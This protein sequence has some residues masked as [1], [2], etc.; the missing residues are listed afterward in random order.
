MTIRFFE[1]RP[2]WWPTR[3]GWILIFTVAV[4]PPSFWTI[5]G[6]TFL[7]AT[8][9]VPAD[10]LVVEGWIGHEGLVAAKTEFDQG[11]YRY[12][13]TSGSDSASDWDG[14][15]WNYAIGAGELLK[16]LGVPAERIIKAPAAEN[17]RQRTFAMALAVREALA[18]HAIH[19]SGINI[20]TK[21]AHARRSRLVYAKVESS[22]TPVG[23]IAWLPWEES[24]G[25]WWGS[26]NRA[27][28]LLKESVGYLFEAVLNSGR[29][30]NSSPPSAPGS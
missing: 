17:K 2:M 14:R 30:S 29:T 23:V 7:A 18:T 1:R 21:G 11:G 24:E 13:V 15:K 16:Q 12:V 22:E 6:E 25:P 19:P 28:T 27:L 3:A 5:Q 10:V 8:N 4:F 26:S 20:F 9:R